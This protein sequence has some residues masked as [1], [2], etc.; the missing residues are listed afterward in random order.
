MA[1][2]RTPGESAHTPTTHLN[3]VESYALAKQVPDIAQRGC[4]IATAYGELAIPPGPLAKKLA[5]LLEQT[6]SKGGAL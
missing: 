1:T 5:K 3:Q 6:L 2:S 4:T